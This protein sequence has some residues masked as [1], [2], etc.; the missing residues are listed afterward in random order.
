M[1]KH[2]L[3][4]TRTT[5]MYSIIDVNGVNRNIKTRYWVWNIW[6]WFAKA[7][8]SSCPIRSRV[9]RLWTVAK[10]NGPWMKVSSW[11]MWTYFLA[12]GDYQ[13]IRNSISSRWG[14]RLDQMTLMR[15]KADL[16]EVN[17]LPWNAEAN[18]ADLLRTAKQ[19]DGWY[20][21]HRGTSQFLYRKVEGLIDCSIGRRT[22][23]NRHNAQ[24]VRTD[25]HRSDSSRQ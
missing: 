17:Q 4:S 6:L 18:S 24:C 8:Q 19:M 20:R 25:R 5:E 15:L 9:L 16:D 21:I 11:S 22:K 14:L 7:C 12:L 10:S 3:I 23:S 13:V 2:V 1:I